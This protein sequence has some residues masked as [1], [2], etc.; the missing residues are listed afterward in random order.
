MKLNL[1]VLQP[2]TSHSPAAGALPTLFAATS[3]EAKGMSYYGPRGFYELKGPPAPA[4]VAPQARDI[5]VAKRLWDIS[6]MLT[7]TS[8]H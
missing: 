1:R 3:P 8:F 5:A 2:L 7:G 4:H 6:E